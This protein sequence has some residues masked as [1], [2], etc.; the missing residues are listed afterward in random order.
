ASGSMSVTLT[1]GTYC[2]CAEVRDVDCRVL[3]Q[4][5]VTRMLPTDDT[6][7]IPLV[8]L[9]SPGASPCVVCDHGR[10]GGD[11]GTPDGGVDMTADVPAIDAPGDDVPSTD[12]GAEASSDLGGDLGADMPDL[13]PPDMGPCTGCTS[14]G[15]A[16]CEVGVA[17]SACGAGGGAC[18]T[19]DV[20]CA[21]G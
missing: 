14:H 2:L 16:T 6:V 11:G 15:G 10:C 17:P 8:A 20:E 7:T 13:G 4:N 9:A 21:G 1:S 5:C 19:C 12:G 3:A 18:G